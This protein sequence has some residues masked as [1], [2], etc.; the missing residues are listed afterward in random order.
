MTRC[1]VAYT[2]PVLHVVSRGEA[3]LLMQL[4]VYDDVVLDPGRMCFSRHRPR[5]DRRDDALPAIDESSGF[6]VRAVMSHKESRG[7]RVPRGI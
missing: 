3:I 5:C 7:L 2:T 1:N 4:Q 6:E